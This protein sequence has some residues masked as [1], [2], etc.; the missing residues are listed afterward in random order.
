MTDAPGTHAPPESSWKQLFIGAGAM[1]CVVLTSGVVLHSL[2]MFITATVLPAIVADIGGV[3]FYAWVTTLFGISSIAGSVLTPTVLGTLSPNR[4]YQ[5]ALLLFLV[6]SL[7]CALAPNMAM[8]IV[9]RALQGFGGGL[10]TA[11]ATTMVP[12]LFSEGLRSRALALISSMWG[13]VALLGPLV[14]GIF[15]YGGLWRGTFWLVLPVTCALWFCGRQVLPRG[16]PQRE[17]IDERVFGTQALRLTLI[18]AAALALSVASVTGEPLS[19]IAGTGLALA[20]ALAALRLD[21][22]ANR[23]LFLKGTFELNSPIGATT[24][25]MMLLVLGVGAGPFVPYILGAAHGVSAVAAGY[26][27]ALSSLAWSLSAL[28]TAGVEASVSRR[29]IAVSPM[30][31]LVAML[32]AG[33]GLWLGSLWLTA[34]SWA[35][36]GAGIGIAWPHL[37]SRV[38]AY[39]QPPDR[40][41]A[42]GFITT[43][44]ILAGTFGAAFAGMV[45]NLTGLGKSEASAHIAY[46]GL[47]LFAC[48]AVPSIVALVAS[49][50][51]L[52]LTATADAQSK[53]L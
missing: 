15:A 51:L 1:R 53:K 19:A 16:W 46:S 37:A 8:I 33:W 3:T 50:R 10:M 6:G 28:L 5:V 26:V 17:D 48:F 29:L 11:L 18:L 32:G 34:L 22:Y 12:T 40:A 36:F 9:G 2:F 24:A 35:L 23:R 45:A 27:A 25:L 42:G 7:I 47:L 20:L 13:P 39:A 49:R 14:G 38:I 43:L 30:C 52:N 41:L 21:R 44:Q 4:G 31:V